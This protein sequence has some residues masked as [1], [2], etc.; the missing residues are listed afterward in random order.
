M[1]SLINSLDSTIEG[2]EVLD[3]DSKKISSAQWRYFVIESEQPLA[4]DLTD[5]TDDFSRGARAYINRR[6]KE[7][8]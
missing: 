4:T 1:I 2:F 6:I 5:S 8:A 7:L 3:I